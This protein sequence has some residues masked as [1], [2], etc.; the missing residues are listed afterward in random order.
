MAT[1]SGSLALETSVLTNNTSL[2]SE[3]IKDTAFYCFVSIG[4]LFIVLG[5]V[6]NGLILWVI[7]TLKKHR[8][9]HYLF[10]CSLAA[11]DIILSGY[12][13][14]WM[15]INLILY[16]RIEWPYQRALCMFNGIFFMTSGICS[17]ISLLVLGVNR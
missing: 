15:V 14:T 5:I 11:A 8:H 7:A 10:V 16:Y 13:M 9:A 12:V 4:A 6:G 2:E 17:V 3:P 1:T